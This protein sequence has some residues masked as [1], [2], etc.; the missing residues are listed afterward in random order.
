MTNHPRDFENTDVALIIGSN[1][2]ENHPLAFRWLEKAREQRGAKVIVV[3]PRFT[4]TAARADLY[5]PIRPGTD[6]AFIGGLINLALSTGRYHEEYVRYYTNASFLIKE[7][8]DFQNGYFAGYD[9]QKRSYDKSS[10]VYETDAD[11]KPV[12]DMTL[13]H[14]RSVF[15][16]MKKHYARYDVETV[17]SV[18]GVPRDRYLEIADAFL[19]SA[20]PEK[21]GSL[22]YAMGGTQHTVGSENVRVYAILQLLL[23]NVGRPGGGVNAMRGHANVQ[24][25]TDLALLWDVLPGYLAVPKEDLHPD[26]ATYLEKE[27]PKSG[28]W[29]NKPKFVVSLLKAFFDAD[30]TKEN[31]FGYDWLP[32][33]PAGVNCSHLAIFERMNKG[34]IRGTIS[35]AQNVVIDGAH[36]GFEAKALEKLEWLVVTDLFETETAAFWKRPGADPKRI[37]TEVFLLPAASFLE[38]SGS[39][40]NTGRVLQWRHQAAKP[41]GEARSDAWIASQ[42]ILRL[43]KLYEGDSSPA[44]VPI[45]K[46][47]WPYGEEPDPVQIAKE[48]NGYD[49]SSRQLLPSFAKLADDGSTAS[50]CWIYTGFFQEEKGNLAD[51]RKTDDP[52]GLGYYPGWGYAWPLNRRILY[53]RAGADPQ[54]APWS[55]DRKT[56]WWD[57]AQ[58]K[59]VGYDVPDFVP[60]KAPGDPGGT[61]PFIMNAEGVGRLFS[62]TMAE[63]PFPEHYE[64]MECPVENIFSEVDLNPVVH[65]F[66]P[67]EHPVGS[68]DKYPIVCSTWRVTEHMGAY[69]RHIPWLAELV[70]VL[71]AEISP[72]LAR[73]RG[74]KTGDKVRIR[75]AR[76]EV[77]AYA[78]VTPRMRPLRVLGKQV[79]QIGLNWHFGYT[80][81][82]TGDIANRLTP[83]VGDANTWIPEYKAFLVDV[84]GVK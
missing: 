48:I 74:L 61:D 33:A 82:V 81:Y 44:A 65:L 79:E 73:A 15:Q 55:P 80:G 29:T 58:K 70:P 14:P 32:K 11:G 8:F 35:F 50:G 12:R 27:T 23:G 40:T 4:R 51:S 28:Y 75:S 41:L 42:L 53:N 56:I 31:D 16:L 76:D 9:A 13:T 6:I 84:E 3:D 22:I 72:S 49:V 54:G 34:L 77:E 5:A 69:T 10:W 17:V 59:W 71:W 30:A 7:G 67:V 46:L 24:G 47:Y 60:T 52:S 62:N 68:F 63:G 39:V 66:D 43:K 1:L 78:L 25:S 64:P 2:A 83:Y 37:P 38:K 26:L 57:A 36:S 18:T 21:A 20:A 45:Q 19:G